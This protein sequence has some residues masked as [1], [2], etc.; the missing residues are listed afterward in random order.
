M[1]NSIEKIERLIS[2]INKVHESYSI[3]YFETGK[4][5]KI[6]LSKTISNIP[7]NHILN[8]RLNLHESIND[9]LMR[10]DL[11]DV[12]YYYRVKTSES[13]DDK[14][15]RHS[16]HTNQYPVNNWLNDIFGCRIILTH[17]KIKAVEKQL[18][19]WYEKYN[20][21]NWYKRDKDGYKAIHVYF[22]NRN[23]L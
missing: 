11:N 1:D 19:T 17:S 4:V 14:I 20:L 21:K 16:H 10:S 15:K 7:R 8:Y 5:K 22:K 3:D 18:D 13:I 9:Y 23:N 12:K 2:E 6:N